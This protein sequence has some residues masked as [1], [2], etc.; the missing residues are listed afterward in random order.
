MDRPLVLAAA[1]QAHMQLTAI[2]A[3][4]PARAAPHKS[5]TARAVVRDIDQAERLQRQLEDLLA[6]LGDNANLVLRCSRSCGPCGPVG[7]QCT[8]CKAFQHAHAAYR[9]LQAA[10]D[11]ARASMVGRDAEDP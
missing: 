2:T 9:A 6:V 11:E 4:S 8:Q 3:A 1:R 5:A 10:L 7:K